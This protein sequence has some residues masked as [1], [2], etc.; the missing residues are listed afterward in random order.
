MTLLDY[1]FVL[2]AK[3]N[4][5]A[6]F[7]PKPSAGYHLFHCHLELRWLHI[8]ALWTVAS[9]NMNAASTFQSSQLSELLQACSLKSSIQDLLQE[10]IE[11]TIIDLIEISVLKFNKVILTL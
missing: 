11:L 10:A 7:D 8:S 6:N 9:W 2:V 3:I 4:A 5:V 1:I